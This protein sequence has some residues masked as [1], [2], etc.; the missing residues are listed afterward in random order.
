[1]VQRDLEHGAGQ[2]EQELP[3]GRELI[4]Q[5]DEGGPL[6]HKLR[7]DGA[8]GRIADLVGGDRRVVA[9]PISSI[10]WSIEKGIGLS[11]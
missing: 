6:G 11:M 9:Q 10:S 5:A 7:N 8:H 3:R 4:G 2:A 1:M